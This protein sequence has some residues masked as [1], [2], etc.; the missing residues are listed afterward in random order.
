MSSLSQVNFNIFNNEFF[1]RMI[2]CNVIFVTEWRSLW[3]F[4]NTIRRRVD[5]RQVEPRGVGGAEEERSFD[6]HTRSLFSSIW[7][8]CFGGEFAKFG[9]IPLLMAGGKITLKLHES[10]SD[11][12][13][14]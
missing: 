14:V 4:F 13:A 10:E 1:V 9:D 5:N 12:E 2:V 3:L 11:V 8:L 6:F 7:S